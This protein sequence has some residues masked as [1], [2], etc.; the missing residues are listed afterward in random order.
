[1]KLQD[2][3]ENDNKTEKM[4]QALNVLNDAFTRAH[5]VLHDYVEDGKASFTKLANDLNNPFFI[6][7]V[8]LKDVDKLIKYGTL[9]NSIKPNATVFSNQSAMSSINDLMNNPEY[10]QKNKGTTFKVINIS[11]TDYANLA[12]N[13]FRK[14]D[15]R[16]EPN[17]E[18]KFVPDEDKVFEYA[19]K[20]LEGS[21]MPMVHLRYERDKDG[22]ESFGQEGRHRAEVAKVLGIKSIPVIIV[23][24]CTDSANAC[25][26]FNK[27]I[28]IM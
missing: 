27:D 18:Y 13:G 17:Y 28:E 12:K 16:N 23:T 15:H 10:F 5:L 19:L 7:L 22:N 20:V 9:Y 2:L 3:Y 4:R 1:M 25:K 14:Y 26:I 21:L 6:K 11:P 8:A 24:T